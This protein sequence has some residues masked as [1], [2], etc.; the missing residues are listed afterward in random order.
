M[1]GEARRDRRQ[2]R[3]PRLRLTPGGTRRATLL[4][5]ATVLAACASAG[6]PPGGP[7]DTTPPQIVRFVPESGA[8]LASPPGEAEIDFDEVISERVASARGDIGGAV[9]LS[10]APEEVDV[11]W[12]RSRI[13]VKPKGGFLPGRVYRLQLLPVVTD[14]RTN[15]MKQGRTI[16]FSTG[17]PIPHAVLRGTV[18]DWGAGHAARDALVEADPLPDT[19]GYVVLADSVGDFALAQVPPG[20]YLVYGVVDQNGN[21]RRDSRE[22]FDTARV[23]LRDS[24]SVQLYAFPHDTLA[25]RIKSVAYADSVTLRIVFDHLLDPAQTG[26]TSLVHVSPADDSTTVL[27]IASVLTPA[28]Y[29]SA[30][31]AA[32]ALRDSLQRAEHPAPEAPDTGAAAPARP[33]RPPP[34][35]PPARTRADTARARHDTTAA[36]RMLARR[37]PPSD[38][39]VVV[40]AEPLEP[41][42]HYVVRVFGV[43]SLTGVAGNR[44]ASLAVPRPR[45]PVSPSADTAH[46]AAR[47]DTAPPAPGARRDTAP[48]GPRADTLPRPA[49]ARP[50]TA[51]APP[52]PPDDTLPPPRPAPR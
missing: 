42:A 17:P 9:I 39:R 44:S 52:A 26:D 20:E 47:A 3:G 49:A 19:L 22:A 6:D 43:K 33:V 32:A 11:G 1:D 27:P 48:P 45:P 29:D 41:G 38:T 21:R 34:L 14:L 35:A 50:D 7:P 30:R 10:P 24:A 40:M 5:A 13:S 31:R 12:H 51:A 25:P 37:P 4:A 28:A 15:K 16:V 36:E 8:V 2:A 23:T 18:V 46:Q